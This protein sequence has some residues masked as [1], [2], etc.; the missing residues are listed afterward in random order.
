MLGGLR[1]KLFKKLSLFHITPVRK[2]KERMP[3]NA[4]WERAISH[5]LGSFRQARFLGPFGTG[6]RV[7]DGKARGK[8]T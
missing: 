6:F 3:V 7:Y 1:P 2:P 8:L 5:I 4:C